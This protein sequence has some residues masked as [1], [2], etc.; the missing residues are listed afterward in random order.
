MKNT[1]TRAVVSAALAVAA[2]GIGGA[3]VAT[4]TTFGISSSQPA[5][6]STVPDPTLAKDLAF[7][8]EEERMARDLYQLFADTYGGA[9]PFS[10]ITRSEQQHFDAVG[11]LLTTYGVADPSAGREAGSYASPEIQ[12]LYDAWKAQGLKSLTDAAQVG[13]ALEKQDIAD[14]TKSISATDKSDVK[15]VLNRLRNAS[16]HHLA[17]FTNAADGGATGSTMQPNIGK[18]IGMQGDGQRHGRQGGGM[19][20]SCSGMNA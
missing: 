17:A 12:S 7:N 20:D 6:T 11:R 16:K 19:Q 15:N 8:R 3:A 2:I 9:A 18:G 13:V 5:A 4:P 14:L 10:M 1:R